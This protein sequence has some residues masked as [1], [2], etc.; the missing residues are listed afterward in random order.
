MET[1]VAS[2]D[3][4][5]RIFEVGEY[6]PIFPRSEDEVRYLESQ[7]DQLKR[8]CES[9]LYQ[10]ACL[11][12]HLLYMSIAYY[13]IFRMKGS[14][15][16]DYALACTYVHQRKEVESASS[17]FALSQMKEADA[18]EFY[19][20]LQVPPE[21][22]RNLKHC[23]GMRNDQMH[24]NPAN[25][26]PDAASF[27][28]TLRTYLDQLRKSVSSEEDLL[29]GLYQDF[30]GSFRS[31]ARQYTDARDEV[32]EVFVRGNS[33]SR[34]ETAS[35]LQSV[36]RRLRPISGRRADLIGLLSEYAAT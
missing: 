31:G 19:R 30:E 27:L 35:L 23:V 12:L 13:Q 15:A 2:D 26:I 34:R 4:L 16:H 17:P 9:R 28:D 5:E 20:V 36:R 7:L 22:I 3:I 1:L 29:F 33:L 6:L 25:A 10:A 14:C 8:S 32:R 11:H 21:V 24:A 18:F